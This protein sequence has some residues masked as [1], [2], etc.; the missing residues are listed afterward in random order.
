MADPGS[1]H[2]PARKA[3][4]IVVLVDGQPGLYLEKG[5]RS[6]LT[7]PAS[8]ADLAAGARALAQRAGRLGLGRAVITRVNGAAPTVEMT[9]V[10][11]QAGF[12]PTP[13][14]LRVPRA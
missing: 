10:L 6:L 12:Q 13:R 3:G 8:D 2:R 11:E 9:A 4:A 14:G 7:F 5:G 1:T